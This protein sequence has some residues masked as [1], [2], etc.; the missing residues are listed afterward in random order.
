MP[1]NQ[2]D[3]LPIID[4][5]R[6]LRVT[7][8]KN[9]IAKADVKNPE[10]CVIA[11][12]VRREHHVKEVR[13]HLGRVYLRANEGNWVRYFTTRALRTEIIAFDRG[14]TFEPGEYSLKGVPPS[15]KLGA[16]RKAYAKKK[17]IG[18][19]TRK[20]KRMTPHVVTNVR[21]GVA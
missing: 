17:V 6:A 16:K 12:A 1:L 20:K 7:I 13:V 21:T 4:S 2:I 14:G 9:D 10:D 8:N 18:P 19:K 5:T 15:H 11:R 3:G